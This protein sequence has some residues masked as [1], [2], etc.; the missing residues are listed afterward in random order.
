[1]WLCVVGS[2]DAATYQAFVLCLLSVFVLTDIVQIT[3]SDVVLYCHATGWK[4]KVGHVGGRKR[5]Y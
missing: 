5:P 1:M 4:D 3:T 2:G